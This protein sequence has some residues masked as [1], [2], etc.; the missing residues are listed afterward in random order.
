LAIQLGLAG[1]VRN[2]LAGVDLVLEG[3]PCAV[4]AFVPALAGRLPPEAKIRSIERSELVPSGRIGFQILAETD[5]GTIST[6]AA[7]DLTTCPRCLDDVAGPGNRRH[8]YAFTSCTD[9]GPRYSIIRELPFERAAT[10]MH[11][12][13][14]C[15]TCRKEY[16]S[17]DDRRFHA[18]TIACAECGPQCW[19]AGNDEAI[20]SRG[21]A[22]IDAAAAALRAGQIVAV[23]G[24]GGY[25]LL[26]DATNRAAVQQLRLRKTRPAKPL[27]VMAASLDAACLLA[28]IDEPARRSLTSSQGPIV[29]VPS[30]PGSLAPEVNPVLGW[31]GLMLPTTPLHWLLA[32]QCPPLVATSGNREGEPLAADELDAERQLG[33]IADFFLHHD[34]PIVRPIDDSVVRIIADRAVTIRA[35]RGFAP[36]RLELPAVLRSGRHVLA[37][38]GQQ[39]GAIALFNGSQAALGPHVGDLD[40]L[41]TRD[42]FVS[43][44][45]ELCQLFG[46]KPEL[47]VHDAHPDY[48]TTC[49]AIDSQLP[50]MSVQHHHAHV[51]VGMIEQDWLDREV[52]G[53]A[54]DGTGYGPDGTIWGGEFL[55]ATATDYR[56]VARL[57]PF[58]LLGG[59][60]AVREPWRAALAVLRDAIGTDAALEF[61][62]ERGIDRRLL[63][64]L[65]KFGARPEHAPITSSIGR[66]F[67]SI[68]AWLLPLDARAR[69]YSLYEGQSA[70]LLET[71]CGDACSPQADECDLPPNY[72]VQFATGEPLELDWRPLVAAMVADFQRGIAPARLAVRF[73]ASLADAIV[74]ISE[75]QRS[76]PVVLCGGVFQNCILT[77]MVAR[78]MA[79]HRQLALPGVIPPNDGGLAA[80]QLAIALA[81]LSSANFLA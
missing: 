75:F 22:S 76:L 21:N 1:H 32:R 8:S 57:R 49:W 44:V 64:R 67:D 33:G 31:I 43:H 45:R 60:A 24:L 71:A 56:R 61:L 20:Q 77:E 72:Q 19:L 48:F 13:A 59:E 41:L 80:G 69:G 11:D 63:E 15:N 74:R 42:R 38:G 52:L 30:R 28:Q 10:A 81:R 25:Q 39:K 66:L 51:V 35:A 46:A 29:V 36:L 23:K 26:A 53:V 5:E 16:T 55:V 27:A 4:D 37:V 50:T 6:P 17:P 62:S 34:R 78:R 54:W 40:E 18:Q 2:T 9:C 73:H 3:T 79:G 58:P 7:L 65:L 14:F 12:F 47:I 70:M 68:A